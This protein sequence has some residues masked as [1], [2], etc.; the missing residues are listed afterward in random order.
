M[1]RRGLGTKPSAV[2]VMSESGELRVGSSMGV[3]DQREP[4]ESTGSF[5]R[6]AKNRFAEDECR[7]VHP[8]PVGGTVKTKK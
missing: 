5:G 7:E 3:C 4:T 8:A 2:T 6:L 1:L